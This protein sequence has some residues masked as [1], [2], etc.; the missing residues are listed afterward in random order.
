MRVIAGTVGGR[1]LRAVP[2]DAVRPTSDR[3]REALFNRLDSKGLLDGARVLD[4]FAGTGALGV[5]A[6]S[7]GSAHVTFVD[8]DPRSIGVVRH[9][10]EALGLHARATIVR[11]EAL[12]FLGRNPGDFDLAL[13]DPPYGFDAWPDLMA[14]LPARTVAAETGGPFPATPGWEELHSRRYGRTTV[15]LLEGQV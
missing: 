8:D 2:G 5:E 10:V 12:A 9:N 6:L 11:S 14:L 3:V 7:R 4:L 1:R 15:T 13:L